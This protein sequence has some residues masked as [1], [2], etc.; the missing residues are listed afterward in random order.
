MTGND[1]LLKLFYRDLLSKNWE[2]RLNAYTIVE[3][4]LRQH[5]YKMSEERWENLTLLVGQILSIYFKKHPP[6]NFKDFEGKLAI[7][8]QRLLSPLSRDK[9]LN[10]SKSQD[11]L[12][13][14]YDDDDDAARA[15]I[16]EFFK[17]QANESE[18]L[19]KNLFRCYETMMERVVVRS[20][21]MWQCSA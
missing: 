7:L 21:K 11:L 2:Q 6:Q 8:Y 13:S 1:N 4:D 18:S 9:S 19:L 3:N 20:K 5:G 12:I 15:E 16:K 17:E 14:I 10:F